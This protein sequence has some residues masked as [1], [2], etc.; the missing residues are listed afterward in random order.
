MTKFDNKLIMLL[1][2]GSLHSEVPLF[3]KEILYMAINRYQIS[4]SLNEF[5]KPIFSYSDMYF[6]NVYSCNTNHDHYLYE[7]TNKI[8]LYVA[9]E[10]FP[11]NLKVIKIITQQVKKYGIEIIACEEQYGTRSHNC[12]LRL[13]IRVSIGKTPILF[14]KSDLYRGLMED[15]NSKYALKLYSYL[16]SKGDNL[17][18]Y[19]ELDKLLMYNT[20]SIPLIKIPSFSLV[21]KHLVSETIYTHGFIMESINEA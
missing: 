8:K 9:Y 1:S 10:N 11:P 15:E 21:E 3:V 5:T 7:N 4:D 18:I 6:D 17:N 16:L 12:H 2:A 19:K 20:I 14:Y 13:E